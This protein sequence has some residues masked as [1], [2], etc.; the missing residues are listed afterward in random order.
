MIPYATY[1]KLFYNIYFKSFIVYE[2]GNAFAA[3]YV[4]FINGSYMND[5]TNFGTTI[6]HIAC[7]SSFFSVPDTIQG[8]LS[9][10]EIDYIGIAQNY[11]TYALCTAWI[12]ILDYYVF[13][14][15]EKYDKSV[16]IN[17]IHRPK[18]IE[19]P[20]NFGKVIVVYYLFAF[21]MLY[22]VANI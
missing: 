6:L 18:Y 20:I 5:N 14:V 9:K 8:L 19:N 1:E 21:S 13:L 15:D 10:A 11:L 12:I 17:Y 7:L 16:T 22:N 2:Y 4:T 3:Q